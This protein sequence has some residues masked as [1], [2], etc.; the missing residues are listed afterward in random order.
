MIVGISNI[1]P[2]E[3]STARREIYC[4]SRFN[5]ADPGREIDTLIAKL[6]AKKRPMDEVRDFTLARQA[7]KEL[8]S[9]K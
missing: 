9:G 4:D 3:A 5:L 7:L 8:E 6:G 2:S 1:G